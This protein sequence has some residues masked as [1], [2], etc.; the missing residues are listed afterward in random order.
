MLHIV[1]NDDRHVLFEKKGFISTG[2][3]LNYCRKELNTCKEQNIES[4]NEFGFSVIITYQKETSPLS[5]YFNESFIESIYNCT[6]VHYGY[7]DMSGESMKKI[8]F[9]SDIHETGFTRVIKDIKNV[10]IKLSN[11]LHQNFFSND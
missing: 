1:N 10:E 2:M 9:E 3:K 4:E 7:N 6:H 8:A 11:K 5:R